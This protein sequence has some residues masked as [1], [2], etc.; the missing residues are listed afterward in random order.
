MLSAFLTANRD[1][2]IARCRAKVT[3]RMAPRPTELELAHGIPLFL[4]Q[5]TEA[6]G[7]RLGT[8]TAIGATAARHGHELLRHGFTVAQVVHDYG[9]ACQ[10]ITE[11]AI[12]RSEP[13]STEEFRALN[14]CV[15]VAI[16]DAVTEYAYQHDLAISADSARDNNEHLGFLAHELRNLL[17][18]ATLAFQAL[19]TGGVGTAG[20]TAAV[21]GRSLTRMRD[22]IDRSLADVR[23]SAG[24]IRKERIGVGAFVEEVEVTAVMEAKDHGLELQIATGPVGVAVEGDRQILASVVANL[25]QNAFKYTRAGSCVCLRVQAPGD[26]V[27]LEVEDECGGLPPGMAEELF[28]PFSQ[29]GADRTGAGLGLVICLKGAEANGGLI[30]V[31]NLPGKGCVFTLDLPRAPE[32][33]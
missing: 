27:N 23:L 29:R 3:A 10:S 13:I 31:R 12:E 5:L 24:M 8:G 26:R 14:L 2:L 20:N 28:R 19:R 22:L 32:L 18:S 33:S 21:L 25:L 6:L 15:D 4:D 17:N 1:E 16:A 30:R 9:D 7:L 11:L